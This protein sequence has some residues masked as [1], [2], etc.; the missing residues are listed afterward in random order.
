MSHFFPEHKTKGRFSSIDSLQN[1]WKIFVSEP[2]FFTGHA[3][4]SLAQSRSFAE[5]I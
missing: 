2:L 4:A 1:A 5:K 3:L